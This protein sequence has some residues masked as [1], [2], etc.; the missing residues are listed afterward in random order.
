MYLLNSDKLTTLAVNKEN[1][2][3]VQISIPTIQEQGGGAFSI[4]IRIDL[5]NKSSQLFNDKHQ[6]FNNKATRLKGWICLVDEVLKAIF[7]ALCPHK[8]FFFSNKF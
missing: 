8:F 4:S 7:L 6:D 5:L 2:I 1:Q 3:C